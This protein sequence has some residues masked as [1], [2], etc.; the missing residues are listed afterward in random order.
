MLSQFGAN[1]RHRLLATGMHML[2]WA[3]LSVFLDP[4]LGL[5]C[6]FLARWSQIKVLEPMGKLGPSVW[7]I[8]KKWRKI[9]LDFS[10]I[11]QKKTGLGVPNVKMPDFERPYLLNRWA[12]S[13]QPVG[14]DSQDE[15]FLAP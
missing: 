1:C 7:E 13:T 15:L 5:F 3:V 4:F 8:F 2:K 9:F 6:H 12:H 11:F 10:M 14:K